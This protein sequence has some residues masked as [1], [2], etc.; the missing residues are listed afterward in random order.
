MNKT[1]S[2][3]SAK[4]RSINSA[5]TPMQG[6]I[7]EYKYISHHQTKES[8]HLGIFPLPKLLVLNSKI[9]CPLNIKKQGNDNAYAGRSFNTYAVFRRKGKGHTINLSPCQIIL[10]NLRGGVAHSAAI[11]TGCVL[12][13][14]VREKVYPLHNIS[15]RE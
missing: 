15:G 7:E 4:T 11:K 1:R 12:Q 8:K 6:P 3:L 5:N 9:S 14:L 2:C 13:F 10:K